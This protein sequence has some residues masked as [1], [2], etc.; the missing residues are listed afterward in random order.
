M[1]YRRKEGVIMQY[2]FTCPLDGCNHVMSVE[3][4]DEDEALGKLTD[5]AEEHLA[6]SH[7]DVQKTDEEIRE[8][9]RSEMTTVAINTPNKNIM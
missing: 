9:I 8:D 7:P 3:A 1:T 6:L 4:K 5:T 2:S